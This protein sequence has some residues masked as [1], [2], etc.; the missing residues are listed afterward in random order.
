MKTEQLSFGR[1]DALDDYA[2]VSIYDTYLNGYVKSTFYYPTVVDLDGN[3]KS[4]P[5]LNI[6]LSK[7]KCKWRWDRAKTDWVLSLRDKTNRDRFKVELYQK[8]RR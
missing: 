7:D 2:D 3:R 8:Q 1:Y 4:D 6:N 5:V